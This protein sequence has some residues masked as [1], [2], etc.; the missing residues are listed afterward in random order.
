MRYA[1]VLAAFFILGST[2]VRAAERDLSGDYG[3]S[4]DAVN[5]ATYQGSVH[6]AK[7]GEVYVLSWVIGNEKYVGFGL[8]NGNVF[9][10]AVHS[11]ADPRYSA[12]VAY[13]IAPN[14]TLKGR[15]TA[16]GLDRVYTETLV[17]VE[18]PDT[19]SKSPD[20]EGKVPEVRPGTVIRAPGSR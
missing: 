18:A 7:S 8:V 17:P 11:P 6:I 16:T 15:W 14:G 1:F 10:V 12:V 20:A 13:T 9:S 3:C 19:A 2:C 5:G 4:G